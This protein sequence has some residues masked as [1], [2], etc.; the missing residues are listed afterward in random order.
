VSY[1]DS[2]SLDLGNFLRD[3]SSLLLFQFGLFPSNRVTWSGKLSGINKWLCPST[4]IYCR[5]R[6][7]YF[8]GTLR[9]CLDGGT[10]K[11]KEGWDEIILTWPAFG[12]EIQSQGQVIFLKNGGWGHPSKNK[13]RGS[14]G[15]IPSHPSLTPNQ[16]LPYFLVIEASNSNKIDRVLLRVLFIS[17][18]R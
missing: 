16:T 4:F 11:D 12:L 14:P 17:G 7:C 15:L 1:L 10:R 6:H 9:V 18:N 5:T 8:L 13:G 3:C 2:D